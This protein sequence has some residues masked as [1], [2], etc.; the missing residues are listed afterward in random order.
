MNMGIVKARMPD[1]EDEKLYK[2]K[3]NEIDEKPE[4]SLIAGGLT[5][6]LYR[7]MGGPKK[8]A[9]G[10][11]LG[12]VAAFAYCLYTQKIYTA[13]YSDVIK[14][15]WR[16]RGAKEAPVETHYDYTKKE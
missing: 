10:A 15:K 9:I 1:I 12:L 3:W 16:N 11:G 13:R 7:I 6:G 4:N 2:Q 14:E 5:G 8:I